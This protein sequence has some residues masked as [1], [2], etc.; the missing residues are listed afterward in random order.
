MP[1]VGR[2]L[3][4]VPERLV[5]IVRGPVFWARSLRCRPDASR[6]WI[7]VG[8]YHRLPAKDRRGFRQQLDYMATLG[9]FI[10]PMQLIGFLTQPEPFEGRY[11]CITFDDGERDAY[12]NAVPILVERGIPATFFVVPDWVSAAFDGGEKCRRHVS[13]TECGELARAGFTIGSHSQSHRRL[14]TLEDDVAREQ[15]VESKS[16][17]ERSLG[18]RCDHFASPWGQPQSDY[19]PTRD[20]DLAKAAGYR[21]FFTTIRGRADNGAS[22]WAIP[23]VRL[24]PSWSVSQ[25][26]YLFAR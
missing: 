23:R 25:L 9:D 26:P 10:T 4:P 14:A 16:E 8:M 3:P 6:N 7:V 12:E 17:I 21:S 18:I 24:E 13:W 20:P 1:V 11:F 5:S 22:C 2:G 15:L 19:N